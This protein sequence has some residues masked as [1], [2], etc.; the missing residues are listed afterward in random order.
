MPRMR[1]RAPALRLGTGRPSLCLRRHLT[2]TPRPGAGARHNDRKPHDGG[3]IVVAGDAV[4]ALEPTTE[5][6]VDEDL[7]AVGT[8]EDADG[9]HAGAAVALP[10][11]GCAAIDVQRVEAVRAVVTMPPA[12]LD[13]A[14]VHAAVA[15]AES[16]TGTAVDVRAA[17]FPPAVCP[18]VRAIFVS[19]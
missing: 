4:V 3:D 6:A 8:S 17:R 16:L 5:A 12:E 18:E 15:A 19:A 2:L 11:A 9:G 13:L 14:R 10:V 1:A 7:L